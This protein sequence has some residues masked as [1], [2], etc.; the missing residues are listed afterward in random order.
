M[1]SKSRLLFLILTASVFVVTND[2]KEHPHP[3]KA[4]SANDKLTLQIETSN[5]RYLQAEPILFGLKLLN[6]TSSPIQWSGL[7]QIGQNTA[8]LVRNSIGEEKRIDNFYFGSVLIG[9]YTMESGKTVQTKS[10]LQEK[11]LERVFPEAGQYEVRI[12]FTYDKDNSGTN[13]EAIISNPVAITIDKPTGINREAFDYLKKTLEPSQTKVSPTKLAML[14]QHFVDNYR[15]S[16]YAKYIIFKLGNNYKFQ[17]EYEKAERELCK[18]RNEN[19]LFKPDVERTLQDLAVKL[20]PMP[21]ILNL[22][23]DAIPP[24]I[25]KPC[26]NQPNL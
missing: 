19:F 17:R 5:N 8:F 13:K 22:P 21:I 16:V 1:F 7:L 26:I 10:I 4:Q 6:Q 3:A 14:Q 23:E 15:D 12:E 25:P 9:Q 2:F 20:R 11:D 18:I 24:P